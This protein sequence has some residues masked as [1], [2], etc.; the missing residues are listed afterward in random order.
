[1]PDF[2][3]EKAAEYDVL[4]IEYDA[5]YRSPD[6]S[7]EKFTSKQL[8]LAMEVSASEANDSAQYFDVLGKIADWCDSLPFETTFVEPEVKTTVAA[9][10]I[11]GSYSPCCRPLLQ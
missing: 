1:M 9:T 7:Y 4:V 6:N 8:I 11:A 2:R 3:T 10:A 5:D